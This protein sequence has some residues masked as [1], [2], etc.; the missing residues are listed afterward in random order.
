MSRALGPLCALLTAGLALAHPAEARVF[1]PTSY[2]LSNGL[3]LIVVENHSAPIASHMVWYRVGAADE[4][5]GKS[6]IAHFLEHLMFKGTPA[7]PAGEF[8][9]IVARNGGAENAFTTQDSTAYFQSVA[10]DRLELAMGLEADRMVNLVL[11]DAAVLPERDVVLEERRQRI[12]NDP[13][14]KLGEMASAIFYLN[15]PYREPIIGWEHEIRGLST[16]DALDFYKDWYAP[17]NAVVIVAGDVAPDAVRAMA[18]R[19][20]GQIPARPVP[21][22]LRPQEPQA[23]APRAVVLESAQVQQPSWS[24]RWLAPSHGSGGG[25]R[26]Y[27]LQVLSEI[28]GGSTVSRLYRALAV[29]AAIATDSGSAYGPD[30]LDQTAFVVWAS[31]RPGGSLE[32]VEAAVETVIAELR[33]SGVSEEEVAQAKRQLQDR[34]ILARDNLETAPRLIGAALMAGRDIEELEAWPE[35]IAEVTAGEVAAAARA[36]FRAEFS[37]TS[38]LRPKPTS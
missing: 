8:S 30:S 38:K 15:H 29:E 3:Q 27:A 9:R 32:E 31:P 36:L 21:E 25:A 11:T 34:A 22:R 19:T 1:D 28:L 20:Y 23:H 7:H 33:V 13:P 14:A 37:V 24:R 12:E 18:E 17:N 26:V 5:W 10:I 6:G 35:R 4:P 2:T 16:A